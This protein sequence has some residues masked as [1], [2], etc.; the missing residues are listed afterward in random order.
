MEK[1]DYYNSVTDQVLDLKNLASLQIRICFDLDVLKNM[2]PEETAK[3]IRRV[4]IT[5]CGDSYSAAGAIMPGFKKLSGLHACNSPDIMD[6]CCFY[7]DKKILKS[8][9]PDEVLLIG[10]S[11]SGASVRVIDA[12]TKAN[13]MGIHSLLITRTPDSKGA[14][15]AE[16]VMDVAT[17]D[18]CNTP[19]LRSYYASLVGLAALGGYIGV[20]NGSI[21][22]EDFYSVATDIKDLTMKFMDHFDEIDDLMFSEALRMK[23]LRKFE[24]LADWNE[25]YSAQFIEQKVIECSGAFCYHTTSEEFA[26]IGFM[27]R[28]PEEIGEIVIINEDDKSLGRMKDSIN[29]CLAQHRP[30][31][32][33]TDIE[34]EN[35][36]LSVNDFAGDSPYFKQ[37]AGHN[38]MAERGTPVFCKIPKAKELW[39]SSFIDFLP[40]SLFA[41]YHAAVNELPFFG[42]RY[43]FRTQIWNMNEGGAQHV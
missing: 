39:M 18:G 6:F 13:S 42:G 33:V 20:C 31:L 16:I 4:I 3:G 11:F 8:F 29:G 7:T 27:A 25:G 28:C 12:L 32:I 10:I 38:T 40:G 5:G 24:L 37:I 35:F 14:E 21:S 43:N 22:L 34:K 17:P 19:G 26:H 23:N 41:G 9:Q 15:T 1:K 2:L 36:D 30:T